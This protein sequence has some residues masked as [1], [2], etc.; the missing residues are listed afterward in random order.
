MQRAALPGECKR[1]KSPE[2]R[3]MESLLSQPTLPFAHANGHW[4]YKDMAL[5][6][7]FHPAQHFHCRIAMLDPLNQVLAA[8]AFRTSP[9]L[10][11]MSCSHLT[12]SPSDL[13]HTGNLISNNGYECESQCFE[14]DKMDFDVSMGEFEYAIRRLSSICNDLKFLL[15]RM[16]IEVVKG[17]VNRVAMR[18]R[19]VLRELEGMA[20][21]EEDSWR[22]KWPQFVSGEGE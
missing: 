14:C 4:H 15:E 1:N 13:P 20:Q 2:F 5:L 16:E 7:E 19:R 9:F 18:L 3:S 11:Q 12:T 17:E 22:R 21:E 6:N 10:V 8:A